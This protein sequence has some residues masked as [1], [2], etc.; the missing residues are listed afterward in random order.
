M[1]KE[2]GTIETTENVLNMSLETIKNFLRVDLDDEDDDTLIKLFW[3]AAKNH[4]ETLI[5]KKM[6]EWEP[7]PPSDITL[8]CLILTQHFYDKRSIEYV[9]EKMYASV[10]S[11]IEPYYQYGKHWRLPTEEVK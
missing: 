8:A 5:Q 7:Q 3:N 2:G 9:S 11:L 4:V 10:N 1:M 6:E